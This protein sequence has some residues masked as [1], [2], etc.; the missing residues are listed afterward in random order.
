MAEES[1]FRELFSAIPI[2]TMFLQF[3]KI[4]ISTE[5]YSMKEYI[6][7]GL[8]NIKSLQESLRK[9]VQEQMDKYPNDAED[10]G[11]QYSE[12]YYQYKNLYPATFNNST[13]LTLYSFFEYNL[14]ALCH[15]MNQQN[16]YNLTVD[17]LS[18]GNYIE[19]SK[20]YLRLVV[21]IEVDKFSADWKMIEEYQQIRNCI[22]HNNSNIIKK[23][24]P[25]H[26]QPLYN[27]VHNSAYL[28]L[29]SNKGTF[30]IIDHQY[31]LD[32]CDVIERYIICVI[33]EINPK[34]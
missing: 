19:K 23:A 2:Q 12:Q 8:S 33:R 30:T 18:G 7:D 26:Q 28:D 13:L 31:L 21:G 17:D 16:K 9:S 32:F 6:I 24:N 34:I 15:T 22:V 29:D 10:I 11:E 14:K 20:K 4:A 27:Y 1:N 5:M 3:H 25:I